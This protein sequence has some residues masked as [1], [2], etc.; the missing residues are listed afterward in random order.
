V[1]EKPDKDQKTEK[2]TPKR[3]KDARQQGQIAKSPDI[4]SWVVILAASFL[5]PN[6]MARVTESVEEVMRR[7]EDIAVRPDPRAAVEALGIGLTGAFTAVIPLLAFAAITGLVVTLAQVGFVFTGKAMAPKAERLNPISGLKKM[8]SAKALWETGKAAAKFA[9]IAAVSVPGVIGLAQQLVGGP[10]FSM[11]VA[12]S[13]V[14]EHL[15]ALVRTIAGLALIIAFADYA[16]QRRT[17]NKSMMMT[18][19]EMKQELKNSEGDAMV[20]GKIRSLQRA[21]SRNR[22]LAA[23]PDAN[24]VIMNP[25]HFA[26]ALRYRPHEGAPKVVAKGRDN[27]ALKIR[28]RAQE[29]GVPVVEAPPLARALHKACELD[30]EIPYSL[31]DGVARVL[32]FVHRLG[33]RSSLTGSFMLNIDVDEESVAA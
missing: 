9:V 10:Q 5:L 25:T 21:A 29:N 22:M 17:I 12:L 19:T 27:L 3:K 7:F 16:Y 1:S 28:D 24:V 18:K 26:V 23:I 6:T 4:A 30:Q 32:A 8:F 20:K 11:S 2:P 33:G 15:V 13:M 14:A 31:F